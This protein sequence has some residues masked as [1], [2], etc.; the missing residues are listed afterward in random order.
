MSTLASGATGNNAVSC[1]PYTS[2]SG[3]YFL[4]VQGGDLACRTTMLALDRAAGLTGN[5]CCLDCLGAQPRGVFSTFTIDQGSDD[6]Y[7]RAAV[8]KINA[9]LEL[10]FRRSRRGGAAG[11][12]TA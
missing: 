2:G 1:S 8:A 7:C 12:T 3:G 4:G 11:Q 6:G 10:G 9:A 5:D